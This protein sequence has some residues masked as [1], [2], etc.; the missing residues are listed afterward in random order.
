MSNK[1]D[2]ILLGYLT[3]RYD[4]GIPLDVQ[5]NNC[6]KHLKG[7]IHKRDIMKTDLEV[8]IYKSN[9]SDNK[10]ISSFSFEPVSIATCYNSRYYCDECSDLRNNSDCKCPICLDHINDVIKTSCNHLFC[11]SCLLKW[12]T[13]SNKKRELFSADC[14]TCRNKI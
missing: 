6:H 2:A 3:R 13:I 11:N 4:R 12:V 14:P 8:I 10:G 9:I 5:C 7:I 1:I